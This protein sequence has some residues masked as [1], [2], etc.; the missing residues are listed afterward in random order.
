[1]FIVEV[2]LVSLTK[3]DSENVIWKCNFLGLRYVY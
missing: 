1:M 2:L 3:D